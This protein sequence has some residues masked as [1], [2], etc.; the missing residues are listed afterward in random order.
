MKKFLALLLAAM[1]VLS[2]AACSS[3]E[4]ETQEPEA[5]TETPGE[6]IAEEPAE[7]A[8]KIDISIAALKGPTA[9]GMLKMMDDAA[10]GTAANNYQFTLAG[11]P[12]EIT[13]NIIQGEF[14][15]AAVPTNLA[16]VLYN[17]TE[18]QV[19]LVALNTLGVL[20]ILETGDTIHSVE[21]LRGK[22]IYA[23]GQGSTPEYALNYILEANGLTV[24]TDVQV[25][26]RSEHAELAQLLAAGEAEI[27]L[28]PQP[29]VTSAM[30]QNE[31][32][33]VALDVTEEWEKATGGAS[34]LTMGCVVAQKSFIEE[35][36][37][38]VAA[39]MEEY[40]ASVE[41]T[42]NPDTLADAAAL[43]GEYDIIASAVAEQAI[44]ECNIVFITG[45]EMK[46]K[47]QGFLEILLEANPDSV[48]GALPGDDFYY[49]Y[50]PAA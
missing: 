40:A 45:D 31:N 14:D 21:D 23:T 15:I 11:S 18:G 43:S 8:E 22:T 47:T 2:L 46:T 33:R 16:S 29:F 1:M 49:G 19:Q 3:T 5:I 26:Y 27:A 30:A 25:E 32:L 6:E 48:G 13:G 50:T 38:A 4:E 28:L 37:D 24:G 36:P 44:P 34:T 7:P 20:Y 9:L 10:N 41:Y 12:D 35:H 39:F 17:K 42:N